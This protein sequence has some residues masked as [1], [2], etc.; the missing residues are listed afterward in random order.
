MA[1]LEEEGLATVI[2]VAWTCDDDDDDN[3]C[4][5]P[6]RRLGPLR[7]RLGEGEGEGGER[8]FFEFSKSFCRKRGEREVNCR[9][10]VSRDLNRVLYV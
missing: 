2:V 6:R 8:V 4:S 3:S 10:K 1:L 5:S 7:H 9:S